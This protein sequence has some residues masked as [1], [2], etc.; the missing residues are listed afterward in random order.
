MSTRQCTIE[1]RAR[2]ESGD[3]LGVTIEGLIQANGNDDQPLKP[4]KLVDNI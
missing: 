3:G 1:S 2:L 4:I